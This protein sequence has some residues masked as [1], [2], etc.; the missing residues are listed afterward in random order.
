MTY[1]DIL[2]VPGDATTSQL[3]KAYYKLA[4]VYH[5]DKNPDDPQAEAKFKD[6][7]EAYGVLSDPEAR[8]KYDK[9]GKDAMKDGAMVDPKELFNQ[10]FGGGKFKDVFGEM[11][12]LEQAEIPRYLSCQFKSTRFV[13]NRFSNSFFS[14]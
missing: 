9:Y 3:R 10:L 1:Y 6:L 4:K 12:L 7:S 8:E 13:L 5:P 11:S 2:G 14:T